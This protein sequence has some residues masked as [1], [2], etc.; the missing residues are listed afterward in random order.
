MLG[1]S[2]FARRL[3][4]IDVKNVVTLDPR[5]RKNQPMH[6]TDQWQNDLREA[7]IESAPG[8]PCIA[9]T[10]EERRR[11]RERLVDMIGHKAD[12]ILLLHPGSGSRAKCWPTERFAELG[13][14][15]RAEGCAVVMT[16][17][18]VE[19]ERM[20]ADEMK[21]LSN[22]TPIIRPRRAID[23]SILLA[24]V[25]AYVGNDSGVSHLAASVGAPTVA[26]FGPTDP[27]LW[28]PLGE[29][30]CVMRSLIAKAWPEVDD[31]FR[32]AILAARRRARA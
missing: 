2:A 7:G 23:L 12:T 28:A 8:P 22:E 29:H 17:G 20:T 6:I 14:R 5:P 13:G 3:L 32:G 4:Q 30:V 19:S 15:L 21:M 25:D 31:V 24:T 11:S 26:I 18:P 9:V 10:A 27:R 16:L 1:G